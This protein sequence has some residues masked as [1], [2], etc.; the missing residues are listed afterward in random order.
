MPR[1]SR[2]QAIA[3]RHKIVSASC[4]LF[5][6]RGFAGVSVLELTAAAGMT[7]GGFYGHFESKESLEVEALHAAFDESVGF[8]RTLT[9]RSK[10]PALAF[11]EIAACFL[12]TQARSD[13]GSACPTASLAIDVARTPLGS[14]VRSAYECG[15][16]KLLALIVSTQS[17]CSGG[18]ARESA[19]AHI[20]MM[21]GALML[22]RATQG[23]EIS[24][25]VLIAARTKLV[26]A[27]HAG[28]TASLPEGI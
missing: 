18:S 2:Q 3:N 6:E 15:L 12:S 1:V 10:D 24:N 14:A 26:A 8:L 7:H 20:S 5:R 4:R 16:E 25:E 17:R 21:V 11:S 28:T 9:E 23:G 27:G 13:P 22:A 19:L